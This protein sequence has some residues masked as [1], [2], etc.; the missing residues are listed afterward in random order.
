[1][2][3]SLPTRESLF[4]CNTRSTLAC[5]ASDI[6]PISS[7]NRVPPSACSNLPLCCLMAEVKEPFS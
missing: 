3:V 2:S 6:S 1:M 7:R 5:A 4:S